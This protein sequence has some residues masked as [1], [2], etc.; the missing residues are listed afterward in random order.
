MYELDAAL[1]VNPYDTETTAT[2]IAHAL[3]MSLEE[4]RERWNALMG[5]LRDNSVAHWCRNFLA[6]LREE[7]AAPLGRPGGGV[8]PRSRVAHA[9]G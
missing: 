8:G 5:R 3:D 7:P 9:A 1:L 6:A 2:A 4:R